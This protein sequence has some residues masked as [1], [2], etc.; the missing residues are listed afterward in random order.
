MDA[1]SVDPA[2]MQQY[3]AAPQ[4]AAQPAPPPRSA[5]AQSFL[6]RM[7]AYEQEQRGKGYVVERQGVWGGGDVDPY[8]TLAGANTDIASL[9]RVGRAFKTNKGNPAKIKGNPSGV[10]Y[11]DPTKQYRLVNESGKNRVLYSGTGLSALDEIYNQ[12]TALSQ[13]MGKKANWAVE[14]LDPASGQWQRRADDDPA[15]NILGKIADI[16]LPIAFSLIPG[17]GPA[18]GISTLG[19]MA[20]GAAAGSA[21]SGAAQ[22]RSVGKILKGAALSGGL[23]FLGGSAL[24]NV[25]GASGQTATS[26]GNRALSQLAA[27]NPG[28]AS[29]AL[30]SSIG[31][32][33]G[34][35]AGS[36]L[37]AAGGALA[38][39]IVVQGIRAGAPALT[40]AALAGA[41]GGALAGGLAT[42][43]A[44][45]PP[46]SQ[47]PDDIVVTGGRPTGVN[48][49]PLA[50][51]A[52]AVGAGTAAATAGTTPKSELDK[53]VDYLQ[54]AG[55][56][57]GL[58]GDV[59]G[60]GSGGSGNNKIPA[61]WAQPMNPTFDAQ[62][63][64]GTIPGGTPTPR[65]MGA[66]DWTRY[67]MRPEQSFLTSVPQGY[68][69]PAP[70]VRDPR[71]DKPYARFAEGGS[72]GRSDDILARLSDGEYVVDAETVALLGDGSNEAGARKLDE[73][74]VNLRKD[75]GRKLARGQFSPK[76]KH[77]AKY[78]KGGR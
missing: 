44:N 34:A 77:P 13:K 22:G 31:S 27:A 56:L 52:A 39:D 67:G 17:I 71:W 7:D 4:A 10:V 26:V 18:L 58:L 24:G 70:G 23:T 9:F 54:A 49:L 32:G 51:G 29:G 48:G 28:I 2:L 16:A 75:K 3:A 65:T 46:T 47:G 60:G 63:P 6:D 41:G 73:F 21:L 57:T 25:G 30:G 53:W 76:A 8:D 64:T 1:Y 72:T 62:L 33:L 20:A 69:P 11:A 45:G 42:S 50:G 19:G 74:R 14:E 5:A 68:T 40:G 55:L 35:A 15:K 37:G 66:Q 43:G 36:G 59:F 61:G 12:A 38:S 78:M